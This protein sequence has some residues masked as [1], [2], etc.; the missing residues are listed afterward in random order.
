M[1]AVGTIIP[2]FAGTELVREYHSSCRIVAH[3]PIIFD[4]R[5]A[6]THFSLKRVSPCRPS[7]H[8]S[9]AINYSNTTINRS[10][11]PTDSINKVL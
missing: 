8:H 2:I 3:N 7:M 6:H 4:S 9:D 5:H 10:T 11:I 1:V